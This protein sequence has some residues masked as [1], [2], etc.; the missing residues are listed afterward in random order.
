MP[1]WTPAAKERQRQLIQQQQPWKH[2]TG[3]RTAAG[4]AKVS[5]NA[6]K[7]GLRSADAI[8]A[9]KVWQK[10][11]KELQDLLEAVAQ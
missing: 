9:Q 3:P 6:Q 10:Y 11:F 8:E 1:R 2:S 4:K 7:H 5:R